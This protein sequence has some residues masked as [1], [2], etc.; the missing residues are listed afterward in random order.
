MSGGNLHWKTCWNPRNKSAHWKHESRAAKKH[1]LR[2]LLLSYQKK[3]WPVGPQQSFLL[4]WADATKYIICPASQSLKILK[5]PFYGTRLTWDSHRLWGLCYMLY[6]GQQK[7]VKCVTKRGAKSLEGYCKGLSYLGD[8]PQSKFLNASTKHGVQPLPIK[9]LSGI[10]VCRSRGLSA[11][12]V[13][14]KVQRV[15]QTFDIMKNIFSSLR[16]SLCIFPLNP[17][18]ITS[19]GLPKF[20]NFGPV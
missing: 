3:N 2:S 10:K 16:K 14:E 12:I 13:R 8:C 5:G 15:S 7:G 6:R 19:H 17:I 20:K 18:V 4:V 1:R 11:D 9:S